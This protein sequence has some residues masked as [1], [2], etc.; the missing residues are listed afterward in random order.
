M[1]LTC[2]AIETPDAITY[3]TPGSHAG[4]PQSPFGLRRPP[5]RDDTDDG[6]GAELDIVDLVSVLE[7]SPLSLTWKGNTLSDLAQKFEA[8]KSQRLA[9]SKDQ[10]EDMY[11]EV[12]EGYTHILGATN[13]SRI[14]IAM[15]LATFY[16]EDRMQEANGIVQETVKD[17]VER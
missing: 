13:A 17:H 10:V 9:G 1:V 15:R 11:I 16:A 3:E 14:C 12:L 7:D 5:I 8:A 4:S 2:T 6:G